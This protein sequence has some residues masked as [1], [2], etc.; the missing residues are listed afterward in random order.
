MYKIHKPH[1]QSGYLKKAS[2]ESVLDSEGKP[3]WLLYYTPGPRAKKEHR[4]FNP[5][6][7]TDTRR[8]IANSG[9]STEK[10]TENQEGVS[11]QA[12]NIVRL[13][14]KL[15]HSAEVAYPQVKELTQA[16]DLITQHGYE[17]ACNIVKF[18][19]RA[20]AETKYQPQTFSGILH[21][22]TP[23]LAAYENARQRQ[24]AQ[25]TIA[26]CEHCDSAG[27]LHFRQADGD[28]FSTPCPHDLQKIVAREKRD[29][30]TRIA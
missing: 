8:L 25:T 19:H 13:F 6:K 14:Y 9:T 1:L 2:Y 3:D 18:A 23:A 29:G 15:F 12:E 30:L 5:D 10:E 24:Q 22:V 21:Y 11:T 16:N 26:Q 28:V 7:R 17:Q 27:F 20:A 4:A